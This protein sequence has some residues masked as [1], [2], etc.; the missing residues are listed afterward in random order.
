M[1]TSH[2]ST[3]MHDFG[4]EYTDRNSLNLRDLDVMYEQNYGVSRKKFER[5]I[6]QR[7]IT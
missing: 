2:I 7:N 3:W 6:P 5:M 1:K 4:K